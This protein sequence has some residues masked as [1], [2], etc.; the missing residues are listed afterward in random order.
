MRGVGGNIRIVWVMEEKFPTV[1]IKVAMDCK[2]N[3]PKSGFAIE[4][5]CGTTDFLNGWKQQTDQDSNDCNNHKQFDEREGFFN[6]HDEGTLLVLQ[7][8]K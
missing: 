6:G 3:L 2:S 7:I 8:I 1:N 4:R 5:A